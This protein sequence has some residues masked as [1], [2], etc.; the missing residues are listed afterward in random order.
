MSRPMHLLRLLRKK[1]KSDVAVIDVS[2]G[3]NDPVPKPK[4]ARKNAA[5]SSSSDK[6]KD[7][8][9]IS[10][11]GDEDGTVETYD[12]CNDV[13]RK[14]N[15]HLKSPITKTQFLRDIVRAAYPGSQNSINIQSKQ[16]SDFLTKKGATAGSTSRVYYAAYVYFE[17]KRLSEGKAK[18]K[19][20]LEMEE[21]WG[22]QGGMPRERERGYWC[23]EGTV[24]V[25]NNLGKVSLVGSGN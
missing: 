18:T 24:P 2:E 1:R 20:R 12:S 17:K 22:R 11:P 4:K 14:I 3:E 19:H 8:F 23:M 13:R 9:S 15:A 5:T 7:L 6:G 10:L 16:L 25:Q 21:Q